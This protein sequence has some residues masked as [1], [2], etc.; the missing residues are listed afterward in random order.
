MRSRFDDDR[1]HDLL[2]RL[3]RQIVLYL[4][5]M[6]ASDRA[7]PDDGAEDEMSR[8]SCIQ[9]IEELSLA[10]RCSPHG[11]QWPRCARLLEGEWLYYIRRLHHQYRE[12]QYR[13]A[14]A[15]NA[16]PA[17]SAGQDE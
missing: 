2:L 3:V 13:R 15:L 16:S 7:T 12:Q 17:D 9:C 5:M 6:R 4:F 1:Y 11:P 10:S 14:A 8:Q